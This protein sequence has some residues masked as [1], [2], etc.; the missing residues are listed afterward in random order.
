MK[1]DPAFEGINIY[2]DEYPTG[3]FGEC[4][5]ITDLANHIIRLHLKNDNVFEDREQVVF[6]AHSMGGIVVRQFLLR[7]RNS[8]QKVPL[9]MFFAT[10]TGGSRKA[11]A[12]GMLATCVQVDDLR[13]LDINSYLESQQSDWLSSGLQERVISYC[14]FETQGTGD[15]L[16]VD[17]SSA[18]LLCTRDPE[19]LPTNH[20]NTV[21]P[22][23]VDDLVHIVATNALKDLPP[24]NL[25][26]A[27][28]L[29]ENRELKKEIGTLKDRL[30]QRFRN[31][32]V[33]EQLGRFLVEGDALL[34]AVLKGPPAPPPDKEANEWDGQAKR[35]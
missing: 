19:A 5:P 35:Y 29:Q 6:L 21:K 1:T 13:P 27:D 14:A 3:L 4:L 10:P 22:G 33:R 34:H 26:H 7:N 8:A 32:A 2:V 30:D 15:S 20:S 28:P 23:S 31:R 17:R 9:V 24:P 16:T 11:T 25:P 18:T 12:V